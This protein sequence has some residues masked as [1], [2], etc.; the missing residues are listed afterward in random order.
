MD[1]I[2][3]N[4]FLVMDYAKY[5]IAANVLNAI[6]NKILNFDFDKLKF[7][8]KIVEDEFKKFEIR[9][10]EDGKEVGFCAIPYYA[11]TNEDHA[12]MLMGGTMMF[13]QNM[14][15]MECKPN[16]KIINGGKS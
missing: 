13:L 7:E 3:E 1:T 9:A 6:D 14:K 5:F 15:A 10:F 11:K 12:R 2:E 16:L 4:C 8:A